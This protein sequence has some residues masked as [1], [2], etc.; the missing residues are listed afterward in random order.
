M[1][2]L[3]QLIYFVFEVIFVEICF[4]LTELA[5]WP[6]GLKHRFYGDRVITIA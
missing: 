5:T 6:R 3:W 4:Q 2:D 1:H